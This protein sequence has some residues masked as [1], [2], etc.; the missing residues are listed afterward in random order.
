MKNNEL[1][2]RWFKEIQNL[3]FLGSLSIHLGC[4]ESSY[5]LLST[6]AHKLHNIETR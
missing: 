3:L 1:H 5:N 2:D 4:F 6:S